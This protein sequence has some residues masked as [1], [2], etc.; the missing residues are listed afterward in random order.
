MR[1]LRRLTIAIGLVLIPLWGCDGRGGSSGLDISG[2]NAAISQA[3]ESQECVDFQG[4]TICPAEV[5][6]TPTPTPTPATPTPVSSRTATATPGGAPSVETTLGNA[7]AIDCVQSASGEP[8]RFTLTFAPHAFPLATMFRVVARTVAPDGPWVVGADPVPRGG[9]DAATFD[10]P[11][12]LTSAQGKLPAQVQLA[13]LAFEVAPPSSPM[14][15]Q[16]LQQTN[17]EFAFVTQVLSVDVVTSCLN[18]AG[19]T[20]GGCVVGT[21]DPSTCTEVALDAGLA[22]GSRVLFN[23][24]ATPVTIPI[25]HVTDITKDTS[26]DGGNLIA[27]NGGGVAQIF[28]VSPGVTLTLANLTIGGGFAGGGAGGAVQNSG[29]LNVT[30]CTFAGNNARGSADPVAAIENIGDAATLTVTN[31]TFTGNIGGID[32]NGTIVSNSGTLTV[33]NSTFSGNSGSAI[34]N[35][36]TLT[37]INSTF[38]ANTGSFG[39]IENGG[40]ITVTG[41][42]FSNNTGDSVGAIDNYGSLSVTNSTFSANIASSNYGGAIFSSTTLTVTN[43]TFAGNRALSGGAIYGVGMA[44]IANTTFAA[45]TTSGAGGALYSSG[46][47]PL[48]V[49]VTNST[50]S[51]NSARTGEAIANDSVE[52]RVVLRNTIV[53]NS[54]VGGNCTGSITDGGH[55]LDSGSSCGFTS[56]A[57]SLNNTNPLLDPEGLANNGGP[58]HTIALQAGSPAINAGDPVVCTAA[59]VN[60]LD[61]RGFDRPVTACSIG[62]YEY[63]L[64]AVCCQCPASCTAPVD[65]SCGVCVAVN[66]ATC[67]D[68][69][70]CVLHTPTSTPT[71]TPTSPTRTP[72]RTATPTQTAPTRTPT[73][74]ATP[75]LGPAD[76]CQCANL[77]AVPIIGTCG[78]CTAVRGAS[79]SGSMCLPFTRSA[80]L[81][82]APTATP[83]ATATSPLRR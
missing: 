31:C 66:N 54:A 56:A 19:T 75:T 59:P 1:S 83:T 76:C 67:A 12:V 44:A 25:T 10:A 3:L 32:T 82:L 37:V 17:A 5:A 14:A 81:A 7:T 23:C 68:G 61:Q 62:A 48:T 21:G 58:T 51:S 63:D 35:A 46:S 78:G 9:S 79:C 36:R 8:C 11:V 53:A 33:I 39:A 57:G 77:C 69:Q 38:S 64:P 4:L 55:N 65:G 26:I 13:V 22:G 52:G 18:G 2:E 72:T 47:L 49:I 30:N 40:T 43:C 42:M 60:N 15:F 74:T 41:S 6:G 24:G 70:L 29:A 80:P 50:F 71:P 28:R 73:V 45:N 16:Q 34:F 20:T 27:L